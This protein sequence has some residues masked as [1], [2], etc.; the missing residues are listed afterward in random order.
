M[1]FDPVIANPGRLKILAAL[2]A[3]NRQEFVRLRSATE[4]TDGN[5]SAHAKKLATAG[6]VSINKRFEGGK[7]LTRFELTNK[8]RAAL[9]SHAR[10]LLA[11]INPA[12]VQ[13]E[14][15]FEDHSDASDDWVD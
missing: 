12:P 6:F 2:A 3:E 15:T 1:P 10:E 8:G 13:T 4:L 11:A 7:P 9:E 14:T 5:L